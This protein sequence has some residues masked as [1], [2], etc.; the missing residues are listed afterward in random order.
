MSDESERKESK[1]DRVERIKAAKDGLAVW[2]DILRY[3]RTGYESIDPDDLELF[4]WY[5]VY[6]QKP[7]VGHFMMRLRLPNGILQAHQLEVIAELT[8]RFAQGYGDVTTRQNIQLHWLTIEDI[9]YVMSRL[10]GVGVLT[11]TAC[12]DA[13]RN[14][15]GC[16]VAG[17]DA[18]ELYDARG[19]LDEV[20]QLYMGN[21]EYSNLPRKFKASISGCCLRC[22][23]PEINDIG[24]TALVRDGEVGFDLQVGGG[25]STVPRLA[26]RLRVFLRPE[27]V[28]PACGA[29][30]AIFRDHGNR[31]KRTR[32]RMKFLVEQWGPDKFL[33]A[34]AER[35]PFELDRDLPPAPELA[36]ARDHLGVHPQKQPGFH[37][38]GLATRLGR[39]TGEQ[40]RE[41]AAISRELGDGT[42][43]LTN[44]QNLI[45]TGVRTSDVDEVVRRA[46]NALLPAEADIWQRNFV[47]CTGSQFCNLAVTATKDAPGV[48][49]PAESALSELQRKLAR[50][51]EF[52]RINYNGCPNSCGQHWIADIG[53]QGVLMKVGGEQVEGALV[54][55]GGGLG[56]EAGFGR[57]TA[58]RLPLNE[59]PQALVRLVEG[60]ERD[61]TADENF[62]A[63][64]Q[65]LDN[66]AVGGYLRGEVA[67]SR[68]V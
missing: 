18:G 45:V 39:I 22:A 46:G 60:Y 67:L 37:Y 38:V 14:V 48:P 61:G 40:M 4:K 5:G 47:A 62:R 66:E 27:Q 41:A 50:F 19:L 3:S 21:P 31:A 65:R 17:V 58:V 26:S 11:V 2:D 8:D 35:V 7:N 44:N 29:I 25:L 13:P 30:A 10:A 33:A 1:A 63:F 51:G 49:S 64:C 24:I 28:R 6:R 23:Q 16:P 20:N 15:V 12:G 59:V 68:S 34:I 9:P 36:E 42:V 32:A 54:T 56:R 57:N 43:R 53:L 55:V 52:I